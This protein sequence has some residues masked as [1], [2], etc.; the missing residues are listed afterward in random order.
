MATSYEQ[1]ISELFQAP[2]E[3]F[4]AERKRLSSELKAAGDKA[5]ATRLSGLARPPVS[6]WAVNQLWWHARA[7]LEQ[8]FRAAAQQRAGERSAAAAHRQKLAELRARA[9]ELLQGAGHAATEATLRRVTM[10]LA[11]L[12][13]AGNFEPD[14]PGA[15]TADRDPPGFEA[16][17]A[18]ALEPSAA[19]EDEEHPTPARHE[20]AARSEA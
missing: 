7:E 5:G 14:A 1:A 15:L 20:R 10:T 11:A 12:A 8:L 4:V 6:A 9:G 17:F 19:G 3:R 18:G 2:H 16:A 13:A